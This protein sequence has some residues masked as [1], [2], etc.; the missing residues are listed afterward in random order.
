MHQTIYEYYALTLYE[1]ENGVTITELQ[2]MLN[3]Y[4]Q[5]EQY[6]ACAGIHR[7]IEHY[8][9]YIL[10]HLITYYTF[11]DDLKQITWTQKEYNN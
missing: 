3:E 6:L 9:F 2:Q 8:K 5:L 4:I 1:L 11:E 7:A 10:Y